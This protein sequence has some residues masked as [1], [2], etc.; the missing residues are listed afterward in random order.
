MDTELGGRTLDRVGGV[1][2]GVPD[3][4]AVGVREHMGGRGV[5]AVAQVQHHVLGERVRTV[6]VARGVGQRDDLGD[7]GGVEPADP[8]HDMLG[9][10]PGSYHARHGIRWRRGN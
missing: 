3:Q 9:V 6:R 1:H 5:A 2:V 8:S 4:T 10:R 7:V